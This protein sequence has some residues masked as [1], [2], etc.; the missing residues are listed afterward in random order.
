MLN[1]SLWNVNWFINTWNISMKLDS[2]FGSLMRS[3]SHTL[4]FSEN[5]FYVLYPFFRYLFLKL[6]AWVAQSCLTSAITW[7]AARQAPLPFT[8]SQSLLKLTSILS[9]M[10]SNHLIL[11]HPLFLMWSVNS[12]GKTL[13]LGKIEGRRRRVSFELTKFKLPIRSPSEDVRRSCWF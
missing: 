7:T 11:C 8:I 9:V 6:K 2:H 13:M 3:N 12:L 10:P 4:K 1:G 5:S